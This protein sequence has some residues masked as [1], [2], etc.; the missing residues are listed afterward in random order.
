M[1]GRPVDEVEARGAG[2]MARW[3]FAGMACLYVL[4]GTGHIASPDGVV[5]SRVSQS[6]LDGRL[7]IQPLENWPTFGGKAVH[8]ETA[9]ESRFYAKYGLG[10]SLV[11]LP[12]LAIGRVLSPLVARTERGLFDTPYGMQGTPTAEAPFGTGNPFR[13]RW[14]DWTADGWPLAFEA[15]TTSW[16]NPAIVAATLA[17]LFLLGCELGFGMRASLGMALVAGF[18]TPLAHYAKTFFAE[19]LAGLALVAFLLA[20]VRATRRERGTAWWWVA[21][22]ALGVAVLAKIAHAVLLVP[23]GLLVVGVLWRRAQRGE[24]ATTAWEIAR[25]AG[26]FALGVCLPLAVIAVYDVARFG[27]PFE[28]GYADEVARWT[29]PFFE[30]LFGLLVSPGKGLLWFAPIVLLSLAAGPRFA[31]R[32]PLESGF[33]A[34]S[35]LA[36]LL[37][38]ARWYMWEGG[39]CWG[40]RFLVPV[41]PLLVLPVGAWLASGSRSVVQ[42]TAFAIVIAASVGVQV[43]GLFVDPIDFH[44]WVKLSHGFQAE[45]F[46][47]AGAPDYY[48]LVRWDWRFS[49]LVASWTFPVQDA[50]LLPHAWRQPGLVLALHGGFAAGVGVSAWRIAGV[51]RSRE[52]ATGQRKRGCRRSVK[53]STASACSGVS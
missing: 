30:G 52:P 40:P 22:F 19:P 23:G 48:D 26:V 39:W 53:A 36:L 28:T 50:F 41:I 1:G 15:W 25:P 44:N 49:P 6:L 2:R 38:Y 4:I 8:G 29:T 18:A 35:L 33:V 17:L 34:A 12:G 14:Y 32:F 46:A 31:R 51:L 7:D 20:L 16:T 11:A 37:L 24:T 21:G 9:P 27:D 47:A 10:Q 42:R 5:M 13:I 45:A 3:L 43:S